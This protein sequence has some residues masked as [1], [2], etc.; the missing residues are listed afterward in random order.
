MYEYVARIVQVIDG[1]TFIANV[2]VG[3]HMYSHQHLRLLNFEA[4]EIRGLERKIGLLAKAKLEELLPVGLETRIRTEKSD[5][6][7][8]W[9]AEV[10][11]ENGTLSEYLIKLGYGVLRRKGE[12]R[13]PFNVDLPYPLLQSLEAP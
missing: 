11:W 3:F 4:P 5:S 1:D 8:R 7:G 2:D 13:V 6:F 12:D 9:L 10:V